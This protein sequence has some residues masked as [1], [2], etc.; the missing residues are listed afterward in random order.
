MKTSN[1]ILLS[2]F[3]I[4]LLILVSVHV[5]LYAKY[6]KGEY[7]LVSDD[8]WPTNMVTYSLNDIKYVSVDNVENITIHAADSSKLE[9]DKSEEGEENILS[10]TRKADTLFLLGKSTRSTHGRWYRRTNLLLAGLLPVKIINSQVHIADAK[11]SNPIS[12][13]ITLDKAFM[14]INHRQNNQSK[15]PGLKIDAVNGSRI[16]LFN[17]SAGFLDVKLK[18]SFLEETTLTADSIRVT[19]DLASKLQ[20]SG[21]NL[22]KTKIVTYE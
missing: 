10:V 17:V 22:I 13:D 11:T 19:T 16:S 20:L 2:T 8:M 3:L 9:Y 14:E 4:V 1:K 18:N 5:A 7:T 15:F 6:K 21:K 12:M